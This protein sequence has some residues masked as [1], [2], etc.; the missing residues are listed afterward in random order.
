MLAHLL[1]VQQQSAKSNVIKRCMISCVLYHLHTNANCSGKYLHAKCGR[2]PP[3][4]GLANTAWAFSKM[5]N[6]DPE[7]LDGIAAETEA[8]ICAYNAQNLANTV[9]NF[10]HSCTV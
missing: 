5:G 2:L 8:R 1:V 4:Q 6:D 10:V 7:L 3:E 9:Q